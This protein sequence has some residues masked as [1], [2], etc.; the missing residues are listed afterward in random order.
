MCYF[1]HFLHQVPPSFCQGLVPSLVMVLNPTL[2]YIIYEYF[3]ALLLEARR[4]AVK[5]M[6]GKR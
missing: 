2:Q 6:N 4:T 1:P 3:T 5:G